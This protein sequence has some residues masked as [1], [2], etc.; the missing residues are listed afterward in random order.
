MR[1]VAL[2]ALASLLATCELDPVHD[3]AV[4]DLGS[5]AP[6]V[7]PGPLHRPGQPCLVCHDGAV[8]NPA[9]S[10]GGTIYAAYGLSSPLAGASVTLTAENGS[11][12]TATTNAAGNFYITARAWQPVYPLRVTVGLGAL[13]AVM[14][15]IIGRDGS[16]ASCHVDPQSRISAGRVYLAPSASFLPDG[17]LN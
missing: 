9:M 3:E 14:T 17:G 11:T 15:T 16:C 12:Y 6:G 4:A 13:T 8:A 1:R 2:A 10:V 5:E 7:R